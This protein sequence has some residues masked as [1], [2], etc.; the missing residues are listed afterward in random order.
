MHVSNLKLGPPAQR[1]GER[2][3]FFS[4]FS[5]A[6]LGDGKNSWITDKCPTTTTTTFGQITP[7]LYYTG[8]ILHQ[9]YFNF[10]VDF[11]RLEMQ[12]LCFAF[13]KHIFVTEI[14]IQKESH[15]YNI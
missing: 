6:H 1:G 7:A 8:P 4:I 14:V 5:F 9:Q 13:L 10:V 12:N 15:K 3:F 11:I 2:I